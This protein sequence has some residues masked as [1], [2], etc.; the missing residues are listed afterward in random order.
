[1]ETLDLPHAR[2][3]NS[4]WHVT[5]SPPVHVR[6]V[7]LLCTVSNVLYSAKTAEV[8]AIDTTLPRRPPHLCWRRPTKPPGRSEG[9]ARDCYVITM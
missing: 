6:H 9:S 3:A 7:A 8:Y 4:S 5:A 1:M 2:D